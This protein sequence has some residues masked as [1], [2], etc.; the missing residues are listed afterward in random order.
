M[1]RGEQERSGYEQSC[2]ACKQ[3]VEQAASPPLCHPEMRCHSLS[4]GTTFPSLPAFLASPSS[5]PLP[6]PPRSPAGYRVANTMVVAGGI[7]DA[8]T[9]RNGVTPWLMCIYQPPVPVTPEKPSLR[10]M[11]IERLEAPR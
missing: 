11:I 7:C 5:P 10:V 2:G 4:K 8:H 3:T 1:G 6:P 9:L